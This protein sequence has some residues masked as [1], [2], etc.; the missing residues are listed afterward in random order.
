MPGAPS[1]G[2]SGE[3]RKRMTYTVMVADIF[4]FIQSERDRSRAMTAVNDGLS[5]SSAIT[6]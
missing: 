1:G 4:H 6:S 2:A 5:D 3:R